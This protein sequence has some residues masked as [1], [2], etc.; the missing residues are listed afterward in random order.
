MAAP[1]GVKVLFSPRG[2]IAD[3]VIREL[4]AEE[5]PGR[6]VVVVTSDRALSEDVGRAGVRTIGSDALIRL[7]GRNG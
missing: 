4:A 3:D 6:V 5:P 1:R 2:V 7:L